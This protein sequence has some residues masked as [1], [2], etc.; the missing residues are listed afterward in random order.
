MHLLKKKTMH[1]QERPVGGR[2]V[3]AK[4]ASLRTTAAKER[5]SPFVGWLA[6]GPEA[7]GWLA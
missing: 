1:Q 4:A 6:D 5:P 2:G 7:R 3:P